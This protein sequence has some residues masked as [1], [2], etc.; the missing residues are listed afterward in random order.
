MF[1]YRDE[2]MNL[3]R[4]LDNPTSAKE[5]F[6]NLLASFVE[7]QR[8]TFANISVPD[9]WGLIDCIEGIPSES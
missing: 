8:G 4:A 7:G 5:D 6:A 2:L 1:E 3:L 9:S